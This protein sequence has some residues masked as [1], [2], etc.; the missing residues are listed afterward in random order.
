MNWSNLEFIELDYN[1]ITMNWTVIGLNWIV[2]LKCLEMIFVVIG[3]YIN[4][5]S[6]KSGCFGPLS[7]ESLPLVIKL[8]RT[9]LSNY[10][11]KFRN[12]H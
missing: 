12:S 4:K 8:H 5:I 9:G 11:K 3:H 2:S 6:L 7:S 1:W 10:I